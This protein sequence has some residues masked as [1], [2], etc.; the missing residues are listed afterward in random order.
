MIPV[1]R[2][3]ANIAGLA[4][5]ALNAGVLILVIILSLANKDMNKTYV[6][7]LGVVAFCSIFLFLYAFGAYAMAKGYSSGIGGVLFILGPLGWFILLMLKD[8]HI[9]K[10][11]AG[12]D[13]LTGLKWTV[14]GRRLI[15]TLAALSYA[16]SFLFPPWIM[17]SRGTYITYGLIFSP[18]EYHVLYIPLLVVEWAFITIMAIIAWLWN[19]S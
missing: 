15:L 19:K 2:K 1:Y 9:D 10:E 11:I 6:D 16:V 3:K 4:G 14:S 18:P 5:L 13:S 7:V 17:I 12:A 8:K